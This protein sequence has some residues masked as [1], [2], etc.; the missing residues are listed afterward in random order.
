MEFLIKCSF[1]NQCWPLTK[2]INNSEKRVRIWICSSSSQAELLVIYKKQNKCCDVYINGLYFLLINQWCF[3]HQNSEFRS[4]HGGKRTMRWYY[5]EGVSAEWI[6]LNTAVILCWRDALL[7]AAQLCTWT[8]PLWEILT[9]F[10]QSAQ[11]SFCTQWQTFSNA[12]PIQ[13]K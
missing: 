13:P 12:K 3:I 9:N 4:H 1:D 6:W 8:F 11:I 10:L 7:I 2:S 5:C